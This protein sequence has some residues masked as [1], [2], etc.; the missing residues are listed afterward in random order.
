MVIFVSQAA[1]PVP[2]T[3]DP[4]R[5]T[6]ATNAVAMTNGN[7]SMLIQPPWSK[8]KINIILI[9]ETGVGKTALLNLLAN[10]CAGSKLQDYKEMHEV[11]NEQ[12]GSESGSQTNKPC[13][14]H[15]VC[16][17]GREVNV[18]DTPGLADT[19]GIDKDNEHKEAIAN[20][21][22]DNVEVIDAIIILANGT[23][24]R[25][26][27]ATEYTLNIISGM[28][29][30]SIINNIAFLFTMVTDPTSFI[31]EKTSLPPQLQNARL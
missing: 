7:S 22:R 26:G 21:I 2:I 12:G 19:R 17:N 9:G 4:S 14:Y 25:L 10:I 15:I 18:L 24:A 27:V 30:H 31:F 28:F 23:L 3:C 13:S 11:T 20:T 8:Q 29:P 5:V 1:A 6:N 16:A